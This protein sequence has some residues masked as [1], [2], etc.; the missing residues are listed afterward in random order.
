[1]GHVR[2][3][4]RHRLGGSA[5]LS[6]SSTDTSPILGPGYTNHAEARFSLIAQDDLQLTSATLAN[7][8]LVDVRFTLT[9][10][11]QVTE[12]GDAA[13]G[14]GGV[15]ARLYFNDEGGPPMSLSILDTDAGAPALRT[16]TQ[17][18]PLR[19]G[20]TYRLFQ[21]L[22]VFAMGDAWYTGI[23]PSPTPTSWSLDVQADHT[24]YGFADVLGDASFITASG[25]DYGFASQVPMPHSGALALAGIALMAFVGRRR[26]LRGGD[27][28][29]ELGVTVSWLHRTRCRPGAPCGNTSPLQP[30]SAWRPW[31]QEPKRRLPWSAVTN[32][33]WWVVTCWN[34]A[35]TAAPPWRVTAPGGRCAAVSSSSAPTR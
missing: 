32:S 27:Q 33:T 11:S 1:M 26:A 7:G 28:P 34:C 23:G 8:T 3:T 35:P 24:A 15:N 25:H 19:V 9:L 29:P 10:N 30:S 18:L 14:A 21:S 20:S 17:T 2:R 6:A 4:V 31:P 12:L 22:D 16:V 5:H 13:V